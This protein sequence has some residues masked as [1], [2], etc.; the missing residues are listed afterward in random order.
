[1]N[2]M[3]LITQEAPPTPEETAAKE[4]REKLP[5]QFRPVAERF[6]REL[7]E[8]CMTSGV[9]SHA[10]GEVLKYNNRNRHA[11]KALS[12]LQMQINALGSVYIT[13]RGWT[14]ENV[15]ECRTDIERAAL[16]DQPADQRI[17]LPH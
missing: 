1:M 17:I 8:Y 2:D 16:L 14:R 9:M 4:W 10:F 3:P 12:V 11:M 5:L 15:E 13:L 6:G 7:F